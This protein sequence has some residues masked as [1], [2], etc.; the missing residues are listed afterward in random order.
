MVK[1][2]RE[3]SSG[4][5]AGP[6]AD[7]VFL[8]GAPLVAVL[9]FLPFKEIPIMNYPLPTGATVFKANTLTTAFIG[10]VIYSHLFIVFFRSHLDLQIFKLHPIRFTVVPVGLFVSVY[11]STWALAAVLVLAVWWDVYHSALQTFGIGRIYDMKKGNDPL[12][13][14]Q[15]D[16]I[17]N[18]LLYAGPILGGSSLML[19][20]MIHQRDLKDVPGLEAAV[21]E[22]IPASA[23]Y[24]PYL[25]LPLL[26]LGIPFCIFYL[27]SYWRLHQRGYRVSFQKT[28]LLAILALVSIAC[29]GFNSFGEAFFVMNFF[30]AWQYFFIVWH[31]ERKNMTSTFKLS[32]FSFGPQIALALFLFIGVGYGVWSHVDWPAFQFSKRTMISLL[33]VIS[34]MHFWYD[35]FIWS[36]R[37]GQ[38]R[39]S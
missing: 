5:I 26:G 28:A 19:H 22:W 13:G 18:L 32:R 30:H 17:F 16:R 24:S 14:R 25:A 23:E 10:I 7:S 11:L 31:T 12:A 15:L 34:I 9:V 2:G 6:I 1:K 29:W 8:I 39:V 35:G 21:F 33:L 36:V 3:P 27:Y 4:F 20:L 38:V 37:K